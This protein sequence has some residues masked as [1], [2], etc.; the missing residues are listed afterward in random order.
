MIRIFLVAALALTSSV[1]A[2]CSGGS[3]LPPPMEVADTSASKPAPTSNADVCEDHDEG[4]PCYEPG[5]SIDCGRV[6][7]VAGD[8]VWCAT[9]HQTCSADGKWGK[10]TG[11]QVAGGDAS[12]Q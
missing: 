3:D 12:A 1:L 5:A 8:Y 11:D 6:K 10:C 4:C 9:G 7:R 2:G